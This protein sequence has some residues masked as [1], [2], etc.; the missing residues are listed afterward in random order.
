MPNQIMAT[1]K[2]VKCLTCQGQIAAVVN[3]AKIAKEL[4]LSDI[5]NKA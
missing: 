2:Y 5:Q 1:N 4:K 3:K